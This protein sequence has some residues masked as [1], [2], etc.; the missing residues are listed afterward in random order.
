MSNKHLKRSPYDPC[1]DC[2][3]YED[4]KG[5]EI[6]AGPHGDSRHFTITWRRVRGMLARKDRAEEEKP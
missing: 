4:T 3:Y 2:W 6:Y 5:I 1:H